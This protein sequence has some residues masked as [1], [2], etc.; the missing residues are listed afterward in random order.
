MQNF[1]FSVI[2]VIICMWEVNR[3]VHTNI[4]LVVNCFPI[5]W[6]WLKFMIMIP[7]PEITLSLNEKITNKS[8][9]LVWCK[10]ND[11]FNVKLNF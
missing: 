8:C 3:D 4:I 2:P 11:P 1:L 6:A 5:Y 10:E 9:S 7:F